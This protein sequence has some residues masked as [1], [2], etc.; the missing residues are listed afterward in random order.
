MLFRTA[1]ER[2]V[3]GMRPVVPLDPTEFRKPLGPGYNPGWYAWPGL[4]GRKDDCEIQNF[5][6]SYIDIMAEKYAEVQTNM[7]EILNF[8]EFGQSLEKWYHTSGHTFIAKA[9]STIF[10][11][12]ND[13]GMGVMS[14]SEVSGR[15]PIF[16]RWHTHIEEIVQQ[17][18][19]MKMA[20]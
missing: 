4:G 19:D 17:F 6:T 16:Y 7:N 8:E 1:I 11:V 20:R 18:R 9:C 12:A 13:T 3:N 5:N 2:H 15:D 10:D 14:F